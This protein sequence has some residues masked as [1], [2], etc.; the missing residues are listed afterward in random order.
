MKK[1]ILLLNMGGPNNI[2][3]VHMFLSNMFD[4]KNILPIN[5]YL[6]KFVA[7]I[8]ITK[9]LHEAE[10]NYRT[11]GGKSPLT[12]IT[13]SLCD[14]LGMLCGLPVRPAMRYVPP[15]AKD[16]L[17]EYQEMGVEELILFPMYPHYSTTTT[18]SSVEDVRARCNEMGYT[19]NI[20]TVAP[21]Y[22][23]IG[24]VDI[25]VDSI[26]QALD[27]LD[28]SEY[29][30]ILSAHGLPMSIINSGDPY[31][32][33]I[34]TNVRLIKKALKK[35]G[36]IFKNIKLAYQSKVGSGAWLEPNLAD[37][38]RKPKHLKVLIY[39]LAFTIDNSETIFEL[40]IEHREIAEKI[41]YDD[42]KVAKC[43]NDSDKFVS[44]INDNISKY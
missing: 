23:D 8:I 21:Y 28:A 32:E 16:A 13:M 40:D 43:P 3:E 38:L 11:I 44:W 29:E 26:L 30:L 5:K 9:R 15:F 37:V 14:K 12:E 34:E 36:I 27:G 20:V 19:P 31:E 1:G 2:E 17:K 4:D 41:G 22:T 42:Y 24:Y 25:E 39:P 18:L 6:R 10:E 35:K 7:N 33:H